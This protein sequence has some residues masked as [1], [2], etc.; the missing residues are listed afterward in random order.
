MSEEKHYV[1]NN[2]VIVDDE[3]DSLNLLTGILKGKGYNVSSSSDGQHALE[4]IQKE[5]PDLI[6]MDVMMSDMDG[7]EVCRCLKA[8]EQTQNIPVIF[9]SALDEVFDKVTA[10]SVGGV[11]Y[12]T[13]PFQ[14]EEVLAHV[15]THLALC[16]MQKQL[17]TQ[18][19]ELQ[20]EISERKRAEKHIRQQMQFLENVLESLTYPFYV[21]DIEDYTIKIAN[22]AASKLMGVSKN[23]TCYAFIHRQE[24]PCPDLGYPC[25]L[26]EVKE[27]RQPVMVEHVHYDQ[28]GHARYHEIHGF[29]IFDENEKVVQMIEYALDI[30]KRKEA[31]K[32]LKHLNRRL[33]ESNAS[34]DTFFSIIAHDLRSPFTALVGLSEIAIQYIDE[35]N[36]EQLREHLSLIKSSAES[37]YVLLENLLTWSQLQRG[38][39]EYH[40]KEF[41]LHESIEGVIQLFSSNVEHKQISLRNL[42]PETVL[43]YADMNMVNTVIRNLVSNALKFTDSGGK[44]EISTCRHGQYI[45]ISV[46][47]TGMGIPEAELQEFFRIGNQATMTG[48]AGEKGT[49]LGL[50]LCR[51]LIKKNGGRLKVES[52][53]EKGTVFTFTLPRSKLSQETPS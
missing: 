35:F 41:L 53:V 48:T 12:I 23:S 46:L 17:Q 19:I 45:E 22:S 7:Y 30:T 10:F 39:M 31:E 14:S 27:T 37:V 42:I 26:L 5:L 15:K 40:P 38:L 44:I 28:H 4:I 49:G 33:K 2:I 52:E 16:T 36:K 25:P 18:N 43:V 21:I 9:V 51:D 3:P 13:K 50:P 47:D 24:K 29:P 34:K 8:D 11:D 6:L 20:Q 1:A 32:Y